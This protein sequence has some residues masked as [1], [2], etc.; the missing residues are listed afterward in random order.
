MTENY[1]QTRDPGFAHLRIFV[2]QYPEW[3]SSVKTAELDPVSFDSLPDTSFAWSSER[4]YPI[5]NRE[6]T[7]LSIGYYKTASSDVPEYVVDNLKTAAYVYG[8]DGLFKQAPKPLAKEAA[9]PTYLLPEKQRFSI[10]CA[11]DIPKAEGALMER[12][13]ELTV[14]DRFEALSNLVKEAEQ[15]GVSVSTSTHKL[16]GFT[17]TDPQEMLTWLGARKTAALRSGHDKVAALYAGIADKYEGIVGLID[18]R[19]YQLKLAEVIDVLDR[20]AGLERH[21]DTKLPDPY[22]TVFNTEKVAA[23]YLN[24]QGVQIKKATLQALPSTFWQD[25]LGEDMAE[26]VV[27]GDA[28]NIEKLSAAL[29]SM[30][31]ELKLVL[32]TQ[33]RPYAKK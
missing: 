12:Y 5:N 18:D 21:Y 29:P 2:E 27:D 26:R 3:Y 13:R 33:L 17:M 6:Q 25:S 30:P 31:P 4:R 9:A 8:V 15:W 28:V 23:D 20:T 24:I 19:D 16:G 10:K 11:E 7:V 14:E 32:S 1:D 22:N